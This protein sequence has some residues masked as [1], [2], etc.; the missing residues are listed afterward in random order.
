MSDYQQ[1]APEGKDEILWEIAKKRASF[2]SHATVY[3]IV[4]IFLW[5]MWFFNQKDNGSGY[6][7]PMWTTLGWGIG[8]TFHFLGAYVFPKVN[9]VE[10]E[11]E[12][13]KRDSR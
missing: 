12:K 4:N 2:K 8:L 9:S 1:K 11:Y 10:R 13:L 6:P 5:G 7:W 3:A